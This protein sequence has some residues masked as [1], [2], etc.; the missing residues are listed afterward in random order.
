MR[1][2]AVLAYL[3]VQSA[4]K[5]DQ[6]IVQVV[7]SKSYEYLKAFKGNHQLHENTVK[8]IEV[9]DRHLA[10]IHVAANREKKKTD[11]KHASFKPNYRYNSVNYR[12]QKSF[13]GTRGSSRF[14]PYSTFN[15]RTFNPNHVER[16]CFSC[17]LTYHP[18]FPCAPKKS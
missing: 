14:E 3:D 7:Q 12:P 11:E 4:L 6:Q 16:K 18:G 13:T 10:R 17:G 1:N 9:V 2:R 5:Y 15:G 8:R